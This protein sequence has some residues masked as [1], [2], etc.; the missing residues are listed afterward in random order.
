MTPMVQCKSWKNWIMSQMFTS[1]SSVFAMAVNLLFLSMSCT[2]EN[3]YAN[4]VMCV[5]SSAERLDPRE[6]NWKMLPTMNAGRG[7]HTLAVLDEKM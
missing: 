1:L 7:C 6:P 4:F 3:L 2:H 5:A